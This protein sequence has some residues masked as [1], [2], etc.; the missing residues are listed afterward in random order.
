MASIIM[1]RRILCIKP[2]QSVIKSLRYATTASFS[3]TAD[4]PE[5]KVAVIGTGV[6]G[7]SAL[8]NLT[9]PF[10]N[11]KPVAFERSASF[12]GHWSFTSNKTRD[13]FGYPPSSAIY[14]G[15]RTN[16]PRELMS[17]PGFEHDD[18][19]PTFPKQSDIYEYLQRYVDYCDLEKYI[20]FNTIVT[21]AVPRSPGDAKTKWEVTYCDVSDPTKSS[22]EEFDAV[23]ICNGNC[24]FPNVPPFPGIDAFQG[25]LLH[26]RDYRQAEEFKGQN[27]AVVGSSYSGKDV[28]R[29]LSDFADK[30]Y[31]THIDEPIKT[32]YENGNV[33]EK[34]L[35]IREI[36]ESSIVLENGKEVHLDAI[37][38]CT[39]YKY[40][41]PFLSEDIIS[42]QNE[43][44]TP[45]YKHVLHL[46]Y[47]SL[48]VITLLRNVATYPISF[49]QAKF[50]RSVIDG[51]AN[52]PSKAE[53]TEDIAL[54]VRW[55]SENN[56]TGPMWH[57][58][59]TLQWN[60]DSHLAD[61]G[62]FEPLSEM[63]QIYWNFVENHREKDFCNYWK[64]D[65]V[66]NGKKMI[67]AIKRDE[68][69]EDEHLPYRM[70]V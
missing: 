57:N 18:N 10:G 3:R 67:E 28:A 59:D 15:L 9:S 36:K 63:L 19:L 8:R 17:F 64:Y 14:C 31:L 1:T 22:T 29:Q 33:I 23:I 55:R 51:T 24:V 11:I 50:A 40:Q 2:L 4:A 25:R 54:E 16:L 47:N 56:M 12:G 7:I 69:Q 65:Y 34:N 45:L 38:M 44:V 46:D 41:F 53:M 37:V 13:E 6:S 20:K 66:M 32:V 58:M 70:V 39:G 35:G 43:H 49:N 52:L 27:V 42:I 30:V 68:H 26:S 61:L 21:N 5:K 60:Y 62:K 48:F